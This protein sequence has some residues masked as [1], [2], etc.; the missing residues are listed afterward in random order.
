M[1]FRSVRLTLLSCLALVASQARA[2]FI[3]PTFDAYGWDRPTVTGGNA[4]F[5]AWDVFTSVAGPNTPHKVSG[6]AFGGSVSDTWTTVNAFGNPNAR[7]TTGSPAVFLTSGGNIYSPSVVTLPEVTI[8]NAGG[9]SA[10]V[11]T[12]LLQV[13]TVGTDLDLNSVKLFDPVSN[14]KLS[15]IS[16]QEIFRAP[17]GPGGN[18]VDNLFRFDVAGNASLYTLTFN[19]L[20]SSTSL[21]R[22]AVDT[23]YNPTATAVPEPSSLLLAVAVCGLGGW[24]LRRVVRIRSNPLV[25]LEIVESIS[26]KTGR[27]TRKADVERSGR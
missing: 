23:F 26:P 24:R 5:Q 17:A 22:V 25:K 15:Y 11:T 10:G 6:P 1:S 7:D 16:T 20:G 27:Q 2:D 8:P 9:Q 4:T 19:G 3:T 13:R 21:D 18:T 14:A 12:I